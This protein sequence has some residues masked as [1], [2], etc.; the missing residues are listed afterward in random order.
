MLLSFGQATNDCSNLLLLVEAFVDYL[1]LVS[2]AL[3][4]IIEYAFETIE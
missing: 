2:Y 3:Q 4:H 1:D